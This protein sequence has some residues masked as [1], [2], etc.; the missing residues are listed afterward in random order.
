M[1][2]ISVQTLKRLPMYLHYLKSLDASSVTSISA[3]CIAD[4]LGCGDVQVR[5]DLATVCSS[6]KPKTG[7]ALCTLIADLED[8]LGYN[9]A[10]DAVLVGAGRLGMALL[11]YG[12]FADYGLRIRHAFDT[13]VHRIDGIHVLPIS[14]LPDICQE[15]AIHIG[16]ITVPAEHAQSVCDT[17]VH[18]G[19]TAI[20]NFAPTHLAVPDGVLV[21]HENMASSLALLSRH[22]RDESTTL[23]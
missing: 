15:Y 20:W 13:N 1:A 3:T 8:F 7:Y 10:T 2:N 12:G 16:I 21:Q 5:K 19:I 22:L 9:D 11:E 14:R 17:L 18:N 4:A 6:G 23:E